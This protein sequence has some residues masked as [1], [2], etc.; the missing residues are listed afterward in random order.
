VVQGYKW[1]KL[2]EGEIPKKVIIL[3]NI[4][5]Y[6]N[7]FVVGEMVHLNYIIKSVNSIE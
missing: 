4:D 1:F 2:N 7:Q 5:A 3:S 6:I